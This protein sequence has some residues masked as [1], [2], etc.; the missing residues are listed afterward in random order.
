MNDVEEIKLM[1]EFMDYEWFEINK[2][3]I[4]VKNSNGAVHFQTDWN[5]LM[6]VVEKCFKTKA[7]YELHKKIEDAL[8]SN[9]ENRIQDV[10]NACVN[11]IKQLEK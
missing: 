10:Y 5:D 8:I 3:Y 9:S 4:A 1:A 11:F 2:P 6:Q 7:N